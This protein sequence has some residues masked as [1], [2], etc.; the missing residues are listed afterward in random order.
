[1][2][3]ELKPTIVAMFEALEPIVRVYHFI[4]DEV[5]PIGEVDLEDA[6]EVLLQSALQ[7]STNKIHLFGAEDFLLPFVEAIRKT[8]YHLNTEIE[9]E[10]N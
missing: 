10:V 3:V 4:G 1:M 8:E 6:A 9:I 2:S 7:F 5:K